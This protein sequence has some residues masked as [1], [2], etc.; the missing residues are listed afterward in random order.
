[1]CSCRSSREAEGRQLADVADQ[2]WLI[3]PAHIHIC[4][5]PDGR[6]WKLGSGTFGTVSRC[7][8][9]SA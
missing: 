1:M 6:P 9:M 7:F 5:R 2:D 4:K 3:D 8:A